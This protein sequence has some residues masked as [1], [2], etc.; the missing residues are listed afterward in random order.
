MNIQ[1]GY[2]IKILLLSIGLSYLIKYGGQLITIEPT[3]ILAL[4]VVLSPSVII[5]LFLG[6]QYSQSSNSK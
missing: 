5:G 2:I 4:I 1:L 3:N 6:R